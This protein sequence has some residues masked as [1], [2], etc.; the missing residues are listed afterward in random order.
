MLRQSFTA[1]LLLASLIQS[2]ASKADSTEKVNYIPQI[3]GVARARFEYSTEHGD[4]RFQVRNARLNVG[5]KVASWAD[6][7]MQADF[8]DRGKIKMLDAW[9][10]IW[11][12]KEIGFQAGQFRMPFGV[13]PFRAPAT[14]IF[15]NRSFVGKQMCNVRAVG[16]KAIWQP[17]TLPLCIEAGAFNPGTIGDHTPWHNTLTFASKLSLRHRNITLSTGFQ[18][19]R[20]D[21]VRANLVDGA[22]GWRSGRWTLEGEYMWKHYTRDR[23]RDAH[24]YL[25]WADY[26]MPLKSGI[27][28]RLSFQGRF[29]GL[30]AHSSAQ[31]DGDGHLVTDDP[32]RTRLTIGSTIS[33][34]RTKSMGLDLRVNYENYF[35]HSGYTPDADGGN[36]LTAEIIVRF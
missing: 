36:K 1:L 3:H 9:A 34:I 2:F 30:T 21:G 20:P 17:S 15:A 24:A 28:N 27:F 8:C 29:D 11:V 32:A 7:Y 14:Y 18:S 35:Y 26:A 33:Y 16:F 31:P 25:I 23:F 4:Y 12:T 22:V 5:G 13:D 10:R 19:V 6:Y